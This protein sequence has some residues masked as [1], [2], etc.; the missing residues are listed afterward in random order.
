MNPPTPD[1]SS[2][3]ASDPPMY[4]SG[5][6]DPFIILSSREEYTR[7]VNELETAVLTM[8]EESEEETIQYQIWDQCIRYEARLLTPGKMPISCPTKQCSA[9]K[10]IYCYSR[11]P[12]CECSPSHDPPVRIRWNCRVAPLS[13]IPRPTICLIL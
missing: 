1:V 3:L 5:C 7:R 4:C 11:D 12:R 2:G 10:C 8:Y 9:A 6:K 13:V